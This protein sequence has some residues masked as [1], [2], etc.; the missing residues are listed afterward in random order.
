MDRTIVDKTQ[1]GSWREWWKPCVGEEV[2]SHS[3]RRWEQGD[4]CS[5]SVILT[6]ILIWTYGSVANVV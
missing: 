4:L 1:P 2:D 3:S 5:L 6:G